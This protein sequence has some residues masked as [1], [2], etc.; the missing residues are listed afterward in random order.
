V[1]GSG[2][3]ALLTGSTPATAYAQKGGRQADADGDGKYLGVMK[4]QPDGSWKLIYDIWNENVT[5]KH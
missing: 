2:D 4:K 5:P 1:D 3:L